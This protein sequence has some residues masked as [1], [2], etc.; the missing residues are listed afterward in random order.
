MKSAVEIQTVIK[1]RLNKER[2]RNNSAGNSAAQAGAGEMTS[3]GF[4]ISAVMI[5][6]KSGHVQGKDWCDI[7]GCSSQG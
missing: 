7:P 4:S 1:R 3:L 5:T 2:A 6:K